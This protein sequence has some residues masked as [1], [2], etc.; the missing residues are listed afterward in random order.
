MTILIA[1]LICLAGLKV[2]DVI[3]TLEGLRLGLKDLNPLMKTGEE[4]VAFS[5]AFYIAIAAICILLTRASHIA[6]IIIAG[7]ACV[8]Y[9]AI[10]LRNYD[11][12]RRKR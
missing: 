8:W 11:I 4:V 2:W 12:L 7:A 9:L 3:L 5:A 10:D 6:S 1:L